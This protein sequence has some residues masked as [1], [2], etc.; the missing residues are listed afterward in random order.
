MNNQTNRYRVDQDW[1]LSNAEFEAAEGCISVHGSTADGV[2]DCGSADSLLKRRGHDDHS[3][4][5]FAQLVEFGRRRMG[6]S[7][8]QLAAESDIDLEELVEIE[9]AYAQPSPRALHRLAMTLKLPVEPLATVAGLVKARDEN[10][11]QAVYRFAAQSE[12]NCALTPQ[13]ED[14]YNSFVNALLSLSKSEEQ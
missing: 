5:A 7:L 9:R 6:L 10:L 13:E 8:E 3:V 2:E 1:L 14:A 4:G 12:P 11:E